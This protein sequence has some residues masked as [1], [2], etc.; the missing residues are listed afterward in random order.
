MGEWAD[1]QMEGWKNG[2]M[3]GW[4]DGCI[5]VRDIDGGTEGTG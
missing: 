5:C 2:K 3:K 4:M 1:G